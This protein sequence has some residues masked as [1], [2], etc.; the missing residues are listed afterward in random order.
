M[1]T[2]PVGCARATRSALP[3]SSVVTPCLTILATGCASDGARRRHAYAYPGMVYVA[4][5]TPVQPMPRAELEDDGLP[6]QAPPM[7]TR[8]NEPDDPTEPFS[9]NYG[10]VLP[11]AQ[12]SSSGDDAGNGADTG[13]G[14]RVKDV[15]PD[16]NRFESPSMTSEPPREAHNRISTS[17]LGRSRR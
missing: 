16:A 9:P 12:A 11:R 8:A 13:V 6:A 2:S 7:R 5:P 15:Q 3:A 17:A 1:S 14:R 4:P 10:T